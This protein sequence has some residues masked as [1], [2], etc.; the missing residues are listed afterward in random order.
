M[1]RLSWGKFFA[2]HTITLADYH[3]LAPT[4]ANISQTYVRWRACWGFDYD[5]TERVDGRTVGLEQD[6]PIEQWQPLG[7]E[8]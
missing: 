6:K 1:C 3:A 5:G 8:G 4:P 7:L 2:R